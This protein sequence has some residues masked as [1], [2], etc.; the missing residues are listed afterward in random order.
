MGQ[1]EAVDRILRQAR[2][3]FFVGIGGISMSSLAWICRA[4]GYEVAGSDRAISAM[5]EK[6]EADGIPVAHAHRAE[7][8]DG[9]DAV[10]WTGAVNLENPELAAATARGIPLI[11]RADLLGWMM[12]AYRHRIGVAGMHGKSTTTAMLGHLF[13]AAG[14]EPTVLCGAETDEMD[15]AYTLGEKEDF[16]FEACEYKDSFL[17]FDPSIAVIL[18]IDLDHADYFTGGL[19]QIRESF[20]RYAAIPFEGRAALPLVV[21]NADD[22]QVRLAT[23]QVPSLVTFGIERDADYRAANIET[24][25]GTAQFDLMRGEDFLGRV[26]LAVPGYHHIYNALATAAVGDRLGIDAET[27][28]AAL[29]SF[30]GV[31]RRFEYKG[32]VNGA[33]VYIDYAHHPKEIAATI[34]AARAMTDRRLLCYFEPHTYSRTVAL[35]D[36]FVSSFAKADRV[37]FLPIYAARE[38][39]IWGVSS[40]QLAR[41]TP[42]GDFCGSYDEAVS[43]IRAQASAGD[44]V[45]ILGAGT[46]D[47]VAKRLFY[48]K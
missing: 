19:P 17:C 47:S 23:E 43:H 39:N 13:A 12:G 1:T 21:A 11:Y 41:T 2:R 48:A 7:N 16:I 14:R 24:S 10:V 38:E 33:A 5:T 44:L 27:I 20:S 40:E 18:G 4:N 26:S 6:L 34:V 30:T 37:T 25:H 32:E 31:R 8:I 15:G 3:L 29:G 35:F 28:C 42:R 45:L 36:E 46:V 9:F 22:E